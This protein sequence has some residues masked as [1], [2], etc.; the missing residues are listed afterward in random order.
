MTAWTTIIAAS[1]MMGRGP[2]GDQFS[3]PFETL[4]TDLN[5]SHRKALHAANR[6]FPH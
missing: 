5:R 4:G 1:A 3:T 2:P 6:Y